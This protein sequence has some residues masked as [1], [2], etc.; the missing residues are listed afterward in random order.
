MEARE[1]KG[2]VYRV[3][4]KTAAWLVEVPNGIDPIRDLAEFCA[5]KAVSGYLI[6]SV[7]R[8]FDCST[9]NPRVA[10]LSSP[11]YKEAVKRARA[12]KAYQEQAETYPDTTEELIARAEAAGWNVGQD[13]DGDELRLSFSQT[14]PAGE[15]FG[16]DAYGE[17]VEEVVDSVARYALDF[18]CDEH[19]REVMHGQGAPDIEELVED[20]K[21]IKNALYDLADSLMRKLI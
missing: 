18:D 13:E 4:T 12:E 15:E 8:I 19:V 17:D 16:F 2:L 9:D 11:E 20:A 3:R 1:L 6:T 7:T 10:V 5:E 21:A 14:S